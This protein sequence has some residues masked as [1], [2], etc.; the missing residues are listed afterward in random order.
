M[1]NAI[2]I[3]A[4]YSADL[5]PVIISFLIEDI[6]V[7][8]TEITVARAIITRSDAE[9]IEWALAIAEEPAASESAITLEH[10]LDLADLFNTGGEAVAPGTYEV[11]IFVTDGEGE[12]VLDR[13]W[14]AVERL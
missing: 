4:A 9:R 1:S 6:P 13:R 3:P 8:G 14:L 10:V 7:D 11:R 5:A 12:H 2:A